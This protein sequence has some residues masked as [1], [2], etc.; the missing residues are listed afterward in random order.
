[1]SQ[2]SSGYFRGLVTGVLVGAATALLLTPKR[3]EDI[4]Q[5]LAE[6]A[7]R[8]KEKAEGLS[9]HL[10]ETAHDLKERSTHLLEDA[11]ER[12]SDFIAQAGDSSDEWETDDEGDSGDE[13]TTRREHA[14]QESQT[15]DHDVVE[16]V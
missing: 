4:R 13:T 3:G 2:E 5:D 16:S 8:L 1:M 6:S 14:R 9:E 12:S 10:S 7:S 11:R 15:Q